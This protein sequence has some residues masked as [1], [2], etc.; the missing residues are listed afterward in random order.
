MSDLTAA[1]TQ[2]ETKRITAESE[3]ELLQHG[4]YDSLPQVVTNPT[5]SAL[6]PQ[7]IALQTEYARLSAA[8]NPGYPKLVELKA[9]LDQDRRAIAAQVDNVAQAARRSYAAA[10][11]QE[12]SLR[13][14][15]QAE[16]Q[17]D[18]ALND[19]LLKD[20]VLSREV[21]TN[22]DLYKNVLQRME[23]I[24]VAAQIPLSNVS[25]VAE[26]A[27]PLAPSRP[28]KK[29]DLAIAG[30][31]SL[32]VSLGL[33][34]L[35]DQLDTRLKT[36]EEIEEYLNLPTLAVAPDFEKLSTTRP[37]Q[38]RL[39][40]SGKYQAINARTR[41]AS[42]FALPDSYK[43]GAGEIYRTIRTNLIFSRAGSPPKTLLFTSSVE[44]EG[45]TWTVLHTA[46]AFAHTGAPTLVVSADLRRPR[47]DKLLNWHGDI[48]L[49]DALI[50]RC[51]PHEVVRRVEG[52]AFSF[53]SAGTPV[54][55]PAE[56]LSSIRMREIIE[57][58]TRYYPFILFDSAPVMH[59]SES[60]AIAAMVDGVVIV[61]G[62]RTAKR[63]V[64][65]ACQ[66]LKS[67]DARLLGV[68]L[69]GVDIR[70]PDYKEYSKY[71]HRYDDDGT[72]KT[73]IV[74][75]STVEPRNI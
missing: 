56:L 1:L 55:N 59:A 27:V 7:F 44:S 3:V 73:A 47:C 32:L 21:Q 19:A 68:V 63:T 65:A 16:K 5:I 2:A 23:E 30:V 75:S 70:H 42:A 20:S 43:R 4:A 38:K 34:F 13:D 29:I 39:N 17:K 46:A 72:D 49:S 15:I 18:L 10:A 54:P 45:K 11:A 40:E 52:H 53:L 31:L 48:G 28:R 50:G 74:T 35:L 14:E 6:K 64:R 71:Y 37:R 67:V 8:F 33:S 36:P 12:A 24:S 66:R 61:V 22:R 60:I 9:Q 57:S 69:N 62:A 58:L 26:G 51:E 41:A 25:P